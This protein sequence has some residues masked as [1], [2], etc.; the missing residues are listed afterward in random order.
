MRAATGKTFVVDNEK[1]S[2]PYD[3]ADLSTMH[4]SADGKHS[5]YVASANGR[6]FVV[7][8][9]KKLPDFGG[10]TRPPAPNAQLQT[11][12][13]MEFTVDDH[14]VYHAN[15]PGSGINARSAS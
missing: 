13:M 15:A 4:F 9:G 2:D 12:R 14:I 3:S 1:E 8:D 10:I 7:L 11:E 6:Q 5:A